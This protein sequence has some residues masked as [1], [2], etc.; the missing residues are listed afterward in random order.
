MR[1]SLQTKLMISFMVVILILV[2][3]ALVGLSLV[4]RDTTVSARQ[5]DLLE[6]GQ[7]IALSLEE[8]F[9]K[10]GTF[11]N[12]DR[13]LTDADSYVGAR[14][15]IVDRTQQVL[16]TSG[17]NGYGPG[18]GRGMGSSMS[19][20]MGSGHMGMHHQNGNAQRPAGLAAMD[21]LLAPVF[22]QGVTATK[23]ALIPYY[24]ESMLT[25]AVPVKLAD[26]T[27]PGAVILM[28]PTSGMNAYLKQL[29][30][31][32]AMAGVIAFAAALLIVA[33]LSRRIVRPLQA[34]EQ[35]ARAMAQ[36]DYGHRV[37]VSGSDE[38]ARLG[39]SLNSLAG[40]LDRYMKENEKLEKLRRD[41]T[42]NVSHEL[43]TPLT[44]IRGYDEALL[45]GAV[46][47]A[48]TRQEY[49]R[50]IQEETLRLERLIHDLLDLSRLQS[51]AKETDAERLP[52]T[53]VA[54]GVLVKFRQLAEQK[55]IELS[56]QTEQPGPVILGN[57]DRVTQL[58]LIFLDNALKYTDRG[59]RVTVG[60][61]TVGTEA[62]V[63]IGDTGRGIPAA[64]I[65]YIWERFYK[66]DKSHRRDEGGTGLG[67]S[68]ARQ[69]I[70]L[71]GAS[72]ETASV[73]G[74][75]TTFTIHFPL[76]DKKL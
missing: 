70:D 3:S 28:A 55:Q 76:A 48:A 1:H 53:A 67:L 18:M 33:W 38:V 41:F 17:G 21:D 51:A 60:V 15:W 39:S 37:A 56:V 36:G 12:T 24:G 43:R 46:D 11:D 6:K 68:I 69:I 64:D 40:D 75:G 54:E 66:V 50:L 59:G 62:I 65:P 20:S 5:Q 71:Y 74:E 4:I 57:G 16:C 19:G 42:A 25:V 9:E 32:L 35:S 73:E 45:A 27:I 10:Q 47:D 61:A 49:C 13:L 8:I 30:F 7:D 26:G 52:L 72:I 63:T 14:I 31:Y 23:T 34:M 2:G 44:I 58:L 22:S 29:Y